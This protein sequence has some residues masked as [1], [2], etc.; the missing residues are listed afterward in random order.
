MRY[1]INLVLLSLMLFCGQSMASASSESECLHAPPKI[2][3][4][5][6]LPECECVCG[7]LD[8]EIWAWDD[9][10]LENMFLV[11]NDEIVEHAEVGFLCYS[12][13]LDSIVEDELEILVVA[14]DCCGQLADFC[15]TIE[16]CECGG[17]REKTSSVCPIIG[18]EHGD[19]TVKGAVFENLGGGG[20]YESGVDREFAGV[21][22]VLYLGD[23]EI[24]RGRSNS[25]GEFEI[26]H[27]ARGQF[28]EIRLEAPPGVLP[29]GF[30]FNPRYEWVPPSFVPWHLMD[31]EIIP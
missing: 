11:L 9:C 21:D 5:E 3:S 12:I 27:V 28:Y 13:D 1:F 23:E 29:A 15:V 8:L 4:V 10:C 20:Y 30:T 25:T 2:C 17:W 16:R 22:V 26:E 14:L 7:C 19:C 18:G 24:A 31:I 6:G